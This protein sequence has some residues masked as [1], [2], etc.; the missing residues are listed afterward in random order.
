[1]S[2]FE[3]KNSS[4]KS[5]KGGQSQIKLRSS[6]RPKL[7][8]IVEVKFCRGFKSFFYKTDFENPT[9]QEFDFLKNKFEFKIPDNKRNC[10]RGITPGKKSDIVKH[11]CPIM[12]PL[13]RSFWLNLDEDNVLDLI[14]NIEES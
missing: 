2:V 9:Y 12:P 6:T 5:W 7:S 11:L 8:D 10:N 14:E 13:Y 4:F 1:M 3:M